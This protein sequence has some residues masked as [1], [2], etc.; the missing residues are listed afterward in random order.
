MSRR[1]LLLVFPALVFGLFAATPAPAQEKKRTQFEYK[2]G[3]FQDR[4]DKKWIEKNPDATFHFEEKKRN[5]DFVELHD[6]KRDYTVRIFKDV[7]L[8][9]GGNDTVKA[10]F[11]E[12]TKVHDGKWTK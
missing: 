1:L 3:F 7:V 4:G 9:K 8:I 6:K 11:K 12:F 10:K 2:G 5:D